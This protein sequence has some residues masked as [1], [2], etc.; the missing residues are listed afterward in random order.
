MI[1]DASATAGCVAIHACDS[2]TPPASPMTSPAIAPSTATRGRTVFADGTAVTE[3]LDGSL[4]TP[5]K[6]GG[7]AFD[8]ASGAESAVANEAALANRSSGRLAMARRTAES[9]HDG[10]SA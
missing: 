3:L 6:S 10:T 5:R 8:G 7:A 9:S 1:G 4:G 2:P